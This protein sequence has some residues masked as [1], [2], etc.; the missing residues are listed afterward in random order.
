MLGLD[1][2]PFIEREKHTTL[3]PMWDLW[4]SVTQD[5]FATA[6]YA[7]VAGETYERGIRNFLTEE[8]GMPCTFSVQR[9]PARRPTTR[10][11]AR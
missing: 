6:S 2:E 5:F 8:M 3:K 1:P 9:A 10:P 4:R 11:S 7:I